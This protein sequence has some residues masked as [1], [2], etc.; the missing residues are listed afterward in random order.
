MKSKKI[1]SLEKRDFEE[2][3]RHYEIEKAIAKRLKKATREERKIIYKTMYDELFTKVPDHPRLIKQEDPNTIKKMKKSKFNLVKRF[4][5]KCTVFVEFGPGD[6]L[7]AIDL[8]N[9]VKFVYGVDISNQIKN[10]DTLPDNFKLIIYDGYNLKMIENSADVAF[11]D[12]LIEHLHPEDI[13]FHLEM[14]RK[15]LKP[16][17][18]YVFRTPH[19]FL[20][21]HD[22]SRFFSDKAEGFHLKEWTYC[23]LAEI[24]R[25]LK[26]SYW[27]GYWY[28]KGIQ[29]K[30]PFI[31]FRI[32]E[33]TLSILPKMIKKSLSKILLP[34]ITMV[35][36]K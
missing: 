27:Y 29:I 30:M 18:V 10:P 4:I 16:K 8:C 14:V 12:Q 24:F 26:Y 22:I 17:G 31:Y 3:K 5:E 28:A 11:S 36:I 21:P 9:H 13:K 34:N 1:K 7:F 19:K 25:D 2:I 6:C 33:G 20:G 35:A 15:I 32:L 23:E